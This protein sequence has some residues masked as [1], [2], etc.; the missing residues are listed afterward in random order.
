M[1]ATSYQLPDLVALCGETFELRTN[2]HCRNATLASQKWAGEYGL[3][4]EDEGRKAAYSGLQV[5]LLAALCFPT[6]DLPQLRLATDFL[7]L[8]FLWN[9]DTLSLESHEIA[10]ESIWLR[11][12]RTTS[13]DWQ[14][15]FQTG[16]LARSTARTARKDH[17]DKSVESY[18]RSKREASGLVLAF[19]LIEYAGGLHIPEEV[20]ISPPM[21]Q[22]KQDA[23]DVITLLQ[24]MVSYNFQQA[25]DDDDNIVAILMSQR[26]LPLQTAIQATASLARKA[27]QSFLEQERLLRSS[28]VNI[29]VNIRTY[30]QGL[31]DWIIGYAHWIYETERYFKDNGEDVR[32]FGWVFLLPK[33]GREN[34]YGP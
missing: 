18:M 27:L 12:R 31:R 30:V 32:A 29:D 16:L 25:N 11:L 5:G 20:L 9:D 15:R 19:D 13:E 14:A 2:N 17:P 33:R 10:L 28:D 4:N 6:C 21:R 23:L 22:L 8:L 34:I 7:T 3:L 26:S 1:P 24:D